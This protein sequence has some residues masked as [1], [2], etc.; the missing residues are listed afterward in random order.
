MRAIVGLCLL[1]V[2]AA[3]PLHAQSAALFAR[4]GTGGFGGGAV[5]SVLRTLN[6]RA[7]GS[8]FSYSRDDLELDGDYSVAIAADGRLMLGSL[9][10]DWH[11]TGGGFRISAG[12]VYNG[13]EGNGTIVPLEPVTVNS[14][15][16]TIEEV[17]TLTANVRPSL[18]LAP[19]GGIGF[20]NAV[21]RRLG[22]LV[23]LGAIY[24]G[25]PDVE[26]I[27]TGMLT[28]TAS[29]SEQIE[30]N[31]NWVQVYPIFSLGLSARVF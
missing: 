7:E 9:I 6:V 20:G 25:S 19:Y 28:P 18:T 1:L 15:T 10:A 31:M 24:L 13:S 3:A 14:R 30:E 16:Y 12:A 17:G 26:L 11:P 5:V 21:S 23:D 27:T 8:Y 2:S 29:E 22:L 4:A